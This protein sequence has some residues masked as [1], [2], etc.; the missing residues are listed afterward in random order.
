[1]TEITYPSGT[2]AE[3]WDNK[4]FV[5]KNIRPGSYVL[6][7]LSDRLCKDLE[8]VELALDVEGYHF[9][10]L[11]KKLKMD[12][13]FV[14]KIIQFNAQLGW[15]M[16]ELT[17][18]QQDDES[19][20]QLAFKNEEGFDFGSI[21]Y[22]SERLHNNIDFLIQA[23]VEAGEY[24]HF[25]NFPKCIKHN[26]FL[27]SL[28]FKE[29]DNSQKLLELLEVEKERRKTAQA[30]IEKTQAFYQQHQDSL[31][32]LSELEQKRHKLS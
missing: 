31:T 9:S 13:L 23:L 12:R 1:M 26:P 17:P 14:E 18:T 27:Q 11:P 30:I 22:A 21:D 28:G 16:K 32:A 15:I 19:L 10:D 5:L 4:N 2:T 3:D 8:I 7:Y 25:E 24:I 29:G 20:W 6:N